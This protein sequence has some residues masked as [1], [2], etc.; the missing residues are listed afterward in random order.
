MILCLGTLWA[1]LRR[2][3]QKTLRAIRSRFEQL[4]LSVPPILLKRNSIL[5]IIF[6]FSDSS[7]DKLLALFAIILS[8]R[9]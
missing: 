2:C 9:R 6:D 1:S 3:A 4:F 5:F 8:N 7:R